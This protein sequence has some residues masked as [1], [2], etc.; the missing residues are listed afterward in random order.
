MN[1][2]LLVTLE[3]QKPKLFLRI[4][5]WILGVLFLSFIALFVYLNILSNRFIK[6]FTQAAGVD[7][8]EFLTT[9]TNFL[10]QLQQNY[11]QVQDLPQKYNFLILGTD[12]LSGREGNPELTDTILLVQ[13]DFQNGQIKTLSLPRDLYHEDYQTRINALYFYGQEKYPEEP[14][15]FPREVL[16]QMTGLKIDQSLVLS[17]EDLGELIDLVDGIEIDVPVAFSDPSF[18]V[19]GVDVSQ[20]SDPKILYKEISFAVG[21]QEMDAQK[22]LE[23]VRSRYSEGD[24]GT[25]EARA[26]RQQLVLEALFKKILSLRSP[27]KL[28]QLYRFYLDRFA[29]Y[30][31]LEEINPLASSY[32]AYLEKNSTGALNFKKHQLSIYPADQEGV[33]YNPPLWQTKQQWLYKIK[34]QDKFYEN[35]QAI[36]N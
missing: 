6:T 18:P 2:D 27:E 20:V 29:K 25:D 22:A 16:E 35:I 30:L 14:D 12:K 36:F 21:Q 8:E 24:E 31:S 23:Y 3:Y 7:K 33:I 4:I 10:N 1:S 34:D 5:L 17:I 26:M 32:L 19:P 15:K 11:E 13:L 28:G 9:S